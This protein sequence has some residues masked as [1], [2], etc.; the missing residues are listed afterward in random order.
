MLVHTGLTP[1]INFV[2]NHDLYTGRENGGD[3]GQEPKR[4]G[5]G[6]QERKGQEAGVPRRQEL[7][8]I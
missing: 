2:S 3:R 8:F 5:V 6:K 1:S 7:F 4:I